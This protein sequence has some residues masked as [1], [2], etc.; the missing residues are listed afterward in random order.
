MQVGDVN[1]D[2]IDDV[3][4]AATLADLSGTSDVGAVYVWLGDA[5]PSPLPSAI[6]S[7]AGAASDS[8]LGDILR[9][10]DLNGDGV[11][12][13]V[14]TE[15]RAHAG[16]V[17]DAGAINVWFGGDD[18]ASSTVPDARLTSP[19]A[20]AGVR[21]GDEE[22]GLL[23][24]D[25]TG[26]GQADLVV[27][28]DRAR[29]GGFQSAGAVFVWEG[30]ST[31][32]GTLAPHA[33]LQAS[34]PEAFGRLSWNQ[35][36]TEGLLVEDVNADGIRDL[37]VANPLAGEGAVFNFGRVWVWAGGSGL[38][39]TPAPTAILELA[40]PS[41]NDGLGDRSTY[42]IR[43]ADVTGDGLT[44]IIVN[45]DQG[46][47]GAVHI[48]PGGPGLSG[49]LNPAAT[50]QGGN[51]GLESLGDPRVADVTGDGVLDVVVPRSFVAIGG[52]ED[53][54]DILVWPGGSGL[55]GNPAPLTELRPKIINADSFF[56]VAG[57]VFADVTGDSMLD[58]VT[59]AQGEDESDDPKALPAVGAGYVFAGGPTLTGIPE[60]AARLTAANPNANDEIGNADLLV[61]DVSGDGHLDVL[62]GSSDAFANRG[63]IYVFEGG[64][65]MT[66]ERNE[67]ALL[68][69]HD[70]PDAGHLF[71]QSFEVTDLSGD[72]V[73]DIVAFRR[74]ASG[75]GV[76]RPAPVF[77]WQGGARLTGEPIESLFRPTD[78]TAIDMNIAGRWSFRDVTG[79]GIT[80]V[81]S[82]STEQSVNGQD[83]AGSIYLWAGQ[84]TLAST[85]PTRTYVRNNPGFADQ[86]GLTFGRAISFADLDDDGIRAPS[87]QPNDRLGD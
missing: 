19:G 26:D 14:A 51:L 78:N 65:A 86:I 12:D 21:L 66:G 77:V 84:A 48:W 44:D 9:L 62:M 82:G 15:P 30:G 23:F 69:Y 76:D 31:L 47:V 37:I 36:F 17:N 38:T 34:T 54:G 81:L 52:L 56:S 20:G 70:I 33:Q 25:V 28:N 43:T 59:T 6:L 40:S 75:M 42:P 60:P 29:V 11:L 58:I 18:L 41:S 27:R 64:P 61:A 3:V 13:I 10:F 4:A 49:T 16:G 68:R 53:V 8:N 39:G 24:E 79:D 50:L 35:F 57:V 71:G 85:L 73:S 87:A 46:S 67:L 7:V 1:G 74:G 2:G 5:T 63:A 22:R 55:V 32:Q 80:D 83:F 45:S 72:G